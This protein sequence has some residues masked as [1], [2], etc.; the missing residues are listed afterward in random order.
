MQKISKKQLKDIKKFS[1][2]GLSRSDLYTAIYN[3]ETVVV[4]AE[5]P[6][7][8]AYA[9]QSGDDRFAQAF[10]V[11]KHGY[12][13]VV[14]MLAYGDDFDGE[15]FVVLEALNI[16]GRDIDFQKIAN[17]I[18]LTARQ[19]YLHGFNWTAS[20]SKHVMLDKEGNVKLIDFNDINHKRDH[21]LDDH[22]QHNCFNAIDEMCYMFGVNQNIVRDKALYNLVEKEYQSLDNVHDPIYFDE[23]KEIYKRITEPG[24]YF[25]QCHPANR[26][27]NDRGK[28]LKN[29][30]IKYANK[31]NTCLDIGCNTGWFSFFMHEAG[32]ITTGIDFDESHW[33]NPRSVGWPKNDGGKI[34]FCK[35]LNDKYQ[36]GIQFYKQSVDLEY[37]RNMKTYDIVL[38]LSILHL[39]FSSLKVTYDYWVTLF[40]GLCKKVHKVLI[41][42]VSA[43]ILTPLQLRDFKHLLEFVKRIGKFRDV[44][45][46]G[47]GAD[48]QQRPLIMC[49]K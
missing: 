37:V 23:Y 41:F 6:G 39:Y 8:L 42:E 31:N 44:H 15:R 10:E 13:N 4:K 22:P 47:R 7:T 29:T 5:A 26:S 24:T 3:E 1:V 19:L 17:T 40:T 11:L 46:I 27:C 45:I 16:I 36:C 12:P 32:F 9:K 14:K 48:G 21:F 49:E 30:L 20:F 2:Q 33:G 34:E 43:E 35:L 38:A 28:L 25:G 18:L